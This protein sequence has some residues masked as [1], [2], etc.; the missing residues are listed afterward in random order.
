MEPSSLGPGKGD[1][2]AAAR[3]DGGA[4]TRIPSGLLWGM[5]TAGW[6]DGFTEA[7]LGG[8]PVSAP[9]GQTDWVW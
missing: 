6:L 4:S 3:G 1:L 9:F 5:S 7:E 8:R 2:R